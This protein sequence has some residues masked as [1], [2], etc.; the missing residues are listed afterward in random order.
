MD[1]HLN[2]NT[3][4]KPFRE[5]GIVSMHKCSVCQR[6]K[7]AFCMLRTSAVFEDNAPEIVEILPELQ[8]VYKFPYSA[9]RPLIDV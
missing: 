4:S 6:K 2:R 5:V 8:M 7:Y 1:T 9:D 3:S